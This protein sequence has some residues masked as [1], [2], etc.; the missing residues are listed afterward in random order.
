MVVLPMW[1]LFAGLALLAFTVGWWDDLKAWARV[2]V[3]EVWL[4]AQ[5]AGEAVRRTP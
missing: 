5:I 3:S 2:C 4:W 1:S